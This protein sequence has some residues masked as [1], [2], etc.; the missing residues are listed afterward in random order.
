MAQAR[1]KKA[2]SLPLSGRLVRIVAPAAAV[3]MIATGAAA[4]P[5]LD[6]DH[7]PAA[8]SQLTGASWTKQTVLDARN[9]AVSRSEER[10]PLEPLRTK[11]AP[12]PQP[13][14][15]P[16]P[17][18]EPTVVDHLYMTAP[19]NVRTGPGDGYSVLEVLPIGTKVPVTG[20]EEGS[21]AEILYDGESRWVSAD[22][23]ASEKP[24]P[25]EEDVTSGGGISDAPCPT[26]SSVEDGL[27]S[28]AVRVHRAVCANF[29][30]VGSYGGL[31][32]DGEHAEGRALDIM[33][34]GSLGDEIAE[35]VRAN[36]DA[37]GVS[38]ILWSQKIWTLERGGEGWRYFED[39]GS[40]AANHY[41]HVHV[42][43]YGDSGG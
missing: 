32:G 43:V 17:A 24:E 29:P 15:A 42:T 14:T 7:G 25:E 38:E 18:P 35:W 16:A 20:A 10:L 8:Q 30:E 2:R 9:H 19:L 31:R 3:A 22:Y 27:T 11:A 13:K 1:H 21:F 36:S 41:D 6:A 37:L 39:R 28:D 23:L 40:D 5:W 34:S 33:A 26:G 12:K 4:V